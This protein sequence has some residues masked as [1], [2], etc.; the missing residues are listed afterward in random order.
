MVQVEAPVKQPGDQLSAFLSRVALQAVEQPQRLEIDVRRHVVNV[1]FRACRAGPEQLDLAFDAFEVPRTRER[2]GE[3][4]GITD[5]VAYGFGDQH[6][7]G[8][9][10]RGYPT[11]HVDRAAEPVAGPPDRFPCGQSDAQLRQVILFRGG[12]QFQG[13]AQQ[14]RTGRC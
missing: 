2:P 12:D 9:S 6:R 4:V 7:S 13:G 3:V 14:R 11:G 1:L 10:H 5:C 8:S